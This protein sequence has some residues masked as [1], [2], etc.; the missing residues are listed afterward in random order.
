MTPEEFFVFYRT[1]FIPIYGDFTAL[2]I[3][4]PMQVLIE[5]S[6]TL[7][8]LSQYYNT[9][10][11]EDVRKDNLKKAKNHLVRVTLDL[12]KLVWAHL[13]NLLDPFISDHRKL[14]CFN[15]PEDEVL[16][17]F[18][19][20]REMGRQARR[21]EV[22]RIGDDPIGSILKYED[23]NAIGQRLQNALDGG[24]EKRVNSLVRVFNLKQFCASILA[25]VV[26]GFLIGQ[27]APKLSIPGSNSTAASVIPERP[28]SET[29]AASKPQTEM[30]PEGDKKL[31]RRVGPRDNPAT[32]SPEEHSSR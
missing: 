7:S 24:R 16:K 11:P 8:H 32:K 10:L 31:L 3:V 30:V 26:A 15:L 14:L 25:S 1:R 29:G 12:H 5:E 13:K 19:D 18:R 4:K 2:A 9:A 17:M 27:W 22:E 20:F 23:V 21:Y 6:N 28:V